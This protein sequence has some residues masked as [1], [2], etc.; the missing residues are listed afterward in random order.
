[1]DLRFLSPNMKA[2]TAYILYGVDSL[3]LE[4]F[5]PMEDQCQLLNENYLISRIYCNKINLNIKFILFY[6]KFNFN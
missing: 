5:K 1:M 6:L 3:A 4:Y 2:S